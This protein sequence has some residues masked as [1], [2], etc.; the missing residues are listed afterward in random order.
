MKFSFT[1]EQDE[2]RS[3]LRRFFADH[4]PSKE[5]RRLMDTEAGWERAGWQALIRDLGLAAGRIPEAF[6]GQ[7]MP[8]VLHSAVGEIFVSANMAFNMY[9]GLTHGAY[10]AILAHG[11]D[12]QK[13]KY[14]PKMV[15]CD[16]TGT[17]NLTE[18][19]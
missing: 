18:P 2:F 8:Y 16:W 13:A 19:H 12:A 17:M 11:T 3:S 4:S 7:N 10:S 5:V 6:G 9:Q 1:H 15:S 14:L